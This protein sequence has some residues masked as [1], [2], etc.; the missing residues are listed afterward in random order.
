MQTSLSGSLRIISEK[1]FA[2]RA[3]IPFSSIIPFTFVSI[4]SSISLEV[5]VIS[6]AEASIRIHSRMGMVVLE[7]TAFSEMLTLFNNSFLA[8]INF[9]M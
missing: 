8:Q 1:S 6:V 7:E 9:I 4:P 5:K 2:S 3:T